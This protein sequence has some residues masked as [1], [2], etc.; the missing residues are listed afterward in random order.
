MDV[1]QNALVRP[2]EFGKQRRESLAER[3]QS[4]AL[5]LLEQ[6]GTDLELKI[7][8]RRRNRRGRAQGAGGG[9]TKAPALGGDQELSHLLDTECIGHGGPH[10]NSGFPKIIPINSIL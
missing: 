4:G 8:H 3:G 9:N 2:Q 10:R 5:P 6:R 1:S 7:A